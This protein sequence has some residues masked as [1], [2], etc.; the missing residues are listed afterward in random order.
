VHPAAAKEGKKG[1]PSLRPREEKGGT[2]SSLS[3]RKR[4]FPAPS[5][6]RKR[7]LLNYPLQRLAGNREAGK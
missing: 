6:E 5:S 3:G 1:D 2:E 7:D 4:V